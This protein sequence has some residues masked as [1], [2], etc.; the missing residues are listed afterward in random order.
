MF[1]LALLAAVQAIGSIVGD[2]GLTDSQAIEKLQSLDLLELPKCPVPQGAVEK[3]IQGK[4]VTLPRRTLE[5]IDLT[6]DDQNG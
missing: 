5:I 1:R 6:S 3:E 2:F 4:Q